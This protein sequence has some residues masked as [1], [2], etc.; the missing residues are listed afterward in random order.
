[1]NHDMARVVALMRAGMRSPRGQEFVE[2]GSGLCDRLT[3]TVHAGVS[4]APDVEQD[5]RA[6]SSYGRSH[7]SVD[8]IVTAVRHSGLSTAQAT[9]ALQRGDFD[10]Y[11]NV[12]PVPAVGVRQC[13]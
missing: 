12:P 4:P 11:A 5:A 6:L 8:A 3:R 2:A 13:A 9:Q 1:M 7:F 10:P